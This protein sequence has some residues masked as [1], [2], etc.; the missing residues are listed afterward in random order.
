MREPVLPLD[1][2]GS[3]IGWTDPPFQVLGPFLRLLF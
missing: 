1:E 2:V 3:S